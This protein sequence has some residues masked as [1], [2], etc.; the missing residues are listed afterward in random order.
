MGRDDRSLSTVY[1]I[2][3]AHRLS[4]RSRA[5]TSFRRKRGC[6]YL[7]TCLLQETFSCVVLA[8][9]HG[10][11]AAKLAP[12]LIGLELLQEIVWHIECTLLVRLTILRQGVVFG[13]QQVNLTQ[14]LGIGEHTEHTV[15]EIVGDTEFFHCRTTLESTVLQFA[16][17]VG[18][19]ES[20]Q[21]LATIKS[22]HANPIAM[23]AQNNALQ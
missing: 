4:Y 6:L 19:D 12:L 10:L 3:M 20:L 21:V 15:L 17:G 18:K 1:F 16:H 14:F 7:S 9:A 11:Y 8:L 2:L 13:S 5:L 22:T 23:L